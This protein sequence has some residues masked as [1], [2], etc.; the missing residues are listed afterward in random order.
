[1]ENKVVEEKV[2]DLLLGLHREVGKDEKIDTIELQGSDTDTVTFTVPQDAK[3]GDTIHIVA[4][5]Q[6]NGKHQLKRY[7]R[8]ILTVK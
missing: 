3:A 2:G 6:D 7:Q 5:V 4:E 8:V 1:M